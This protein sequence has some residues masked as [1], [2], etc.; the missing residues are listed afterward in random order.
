MLGRGEYQ[1]QYVHRI[2]GTGALDE[3]QASSR[4]DAR[5]RVFERLRDK[6]RGAAQ[7]WIAENY[8]QIG[9]TCTLDLEATYR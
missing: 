8:E 1:S 2:D 4:L 9:R 3:Y 6:G 5:W 7:A